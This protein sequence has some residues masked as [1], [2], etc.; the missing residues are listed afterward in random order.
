[1]DEHHKLHEGGREKSIYNNGSFLW[2]LNRLTS[3]ALKIPSIKNPY[4][5]VMA[6]PFYLISIF[7]FF[8]FFYKSANY[9]FLM[10]VHLSP[11]FSFI[12]KSAVQG[13]AGN[14]LPKCILDVNIICFSALQCSDFFPLYLKKWCRHKTSRKRFSLL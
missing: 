4:R 9:Y 2:K 5:Y 8:L 3:D 1:M 7:S 11:L 10:N 14:N 13:I 12:D 6:I